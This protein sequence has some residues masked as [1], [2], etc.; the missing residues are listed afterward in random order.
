M[1]DERDHSRADTV[2]DGLHEREPAEVDIERAHGGDD[3][4]V[5]KNERPASCPGSPE[6]APD[7]GDPDADLD[8]ERPWQGLADRDALAHLVLREPLLVADQLT[9]HLTDERH[10]P[11]EAEK[12]KAQEVAHEIAKG[13]AVGRL[14]SAH[15]WFSC[16]P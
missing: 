7:V 8:G 13:N 1:Q 2:K 14:L 12:T 6:A 3:N 9:L 5:G 16:G 4:E 15:H 11:A 10:G